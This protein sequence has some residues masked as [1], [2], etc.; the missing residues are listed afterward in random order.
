MTIEEEKYIEA[1]ERQ[2]D[3]QEKYI[4]ELKKTFEL[5]VTII[6]GTGPENIELISAAK[7]LV[8]WL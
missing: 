1:L 5:L 7:S 4:E 2:I 3:A 8:K 6:E